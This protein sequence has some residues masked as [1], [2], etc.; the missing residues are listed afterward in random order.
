LNNK[1]LYEHYLLPQMSTLTVAEDETL[2][3]HPN[4]DWSM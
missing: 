2:N 1:Q 4:R 3:C